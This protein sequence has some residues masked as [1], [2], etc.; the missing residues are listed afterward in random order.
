MKKDYFGL[1]LM[2]VITLVLSFMLLTSRFSE[3][4]NTSLFAGKAF[5]QSAFVG[6]RN[7][8][9]F[10]LFKSLGLFFGLTIYFIISKEGKK[11]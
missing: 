8:F 6:A 11:K 10:S 5:Y 2:F 4:A 9:F 3:P 1:L 7:L